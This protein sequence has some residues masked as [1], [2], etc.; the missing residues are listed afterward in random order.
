MKKLNDSSFK[1]G[2]SL[3]KQ[4]KQTNSNKVISKKKTIKNNKRNNFKPK[5]EVH[6]IPFEYF[7][8]ILEK[9]DKDAI[10]LIKNNDVIKFSTSSDKLIFYMLNNL[11][12]I[13]SDNIYTLYKNNELLLKSKSK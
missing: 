6:V 12:L 3:T 7:S 1:L 5:E 11:K 8:S 13:I 4:H 2:K 10:K 9:V